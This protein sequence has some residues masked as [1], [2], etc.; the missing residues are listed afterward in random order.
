MRFPARKKIFP[1]YW[2]KIHENKSFK[3]TIFKSIIKL[4][5]HNYCYKSNNT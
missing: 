5:G 2:Y 1:L 4:I 3:N